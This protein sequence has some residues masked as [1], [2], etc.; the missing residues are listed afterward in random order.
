MAKLDMFTWTSVPQIQVWA[1]FV[2]GAELT[3][4]TPDRLGGL[5]VRR[6]EFRRGDDSPGL[7]F[8]KDSL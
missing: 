7:V 8:Y 2:S 4:P 1:I 5:H 6:S 3:S